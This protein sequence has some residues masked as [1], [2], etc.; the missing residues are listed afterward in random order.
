MVASSRK[1]GRRLAWGLQ[2]ADTGE[3]SKFY[4]GKEKAGAWDSVSQSVFEEH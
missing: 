1:Q 3:K 2:N 4:G